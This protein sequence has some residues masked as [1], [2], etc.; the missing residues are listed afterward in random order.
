MEAESRYVEWTH[1]FAGTYSHFTMSPDGTVS[2]WNDHYLEDCDKNR[3]LLLL[4]GEEIAYTYKYLNE[5]T[6]PCSL[7]FW[8]S[9][10]MSFY[11]KDAVKKN[12]HNNELKCVQSLMKD[13]NKGL[14]NTFLEI[15]KSEDCKN[16]IH[17]YE[18]EQQRLAQELASTEHVFYQKFDNIA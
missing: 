14:L 12:V 1:N 13:E 17:E 6:S 5:P 11:D 9:E 10:L 2:A 3:E 7:A 4:S 8:E 16:E 18:A 15:M